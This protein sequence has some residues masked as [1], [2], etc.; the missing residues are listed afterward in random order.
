M[1]L[2]KLQFP[3]L[4]DEFANYGT[5]RAIIQ[6]AKRIV[7]ICIECKKYTLAEKISRKYG[8]DKKSD[9]FINATSLA[10]LAKNKFI[11]REES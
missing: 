5:N 10:F 6:K 9:D 8:L 2:D 3:S 4:I 7:R 11:N 1:N